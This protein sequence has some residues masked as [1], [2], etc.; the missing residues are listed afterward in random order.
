[1]TKLL[2]RTKV[3]ALSVRTVSGQAWTLAE[4]KPER[5]TLVVFYRGLHCLSA[6]AISASSSSLSQSSGREASRW[7]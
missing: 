2:P 7:L 6:A 3:P 4:R 5:F 1:M